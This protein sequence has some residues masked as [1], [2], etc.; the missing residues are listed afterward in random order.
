MRR[1]ALY[2]MVLPSWMMVGYRLRMSV[3]EAAAV[4]IARRFLSV[5]LTFHGDG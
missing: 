3:K 5:S 4:A 1:V 2:V